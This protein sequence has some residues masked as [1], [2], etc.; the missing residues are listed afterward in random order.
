MCDFGLSQVRQSTWMT[1]H[2]QAGSPSWTAP[3]VLTNQHYNEKSDIWSMG[4]R[5][6]SG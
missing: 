3:E 5:P 1:N 2:N 6:R 4:V